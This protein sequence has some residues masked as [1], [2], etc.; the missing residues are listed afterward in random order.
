VRA[1]ASTMASP[2]S[3]AW[4][5]TAVKILLRMPMMVFLYALR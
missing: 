1:L 5:L 2:A 4:P 3:E